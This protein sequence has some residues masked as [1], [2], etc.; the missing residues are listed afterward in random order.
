MNSYDEFK[1]INRSTVPDNNAVTI[2]SVDLHHDLCIVETRDRKYKLLPIEVLIICMQKNNIHIDNFPR[3]RKWTGF[4]NEYTTNVMHGSKQFPGGIDSV[5]PNV[6]DVT[7][8][9]D[10]YAVYRKIGDKL[11]AAYYYG[12]P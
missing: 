11:I 5:N 6:V 7:D 10:F 4:S 8:A 2:V 1:N 3:L 12:K 9:L